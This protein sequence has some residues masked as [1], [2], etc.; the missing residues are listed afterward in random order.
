L[1]RTI[2][3]TQCW[4][5]KGEGWLEGSICADCNGVGEVKD[6]KKIYLRALDIYLKHA[7]PDNATARMLKKNMAFNNGFFYGGVPSEAKFGC[8]NNGHM[9]L[10]VSKDGELFVYT[11]DIGTGKSAIAIN[12]EIKQ[13]IEQAWKE[14]GLPVMQNGGT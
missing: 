11:N 8:Y 4:S 3:K 5:C 7:F 2:A 10:R 6:Q 12:W 9:K 13:S 14:S 1:T